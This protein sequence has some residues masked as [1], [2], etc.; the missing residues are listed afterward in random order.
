MA[1]FRINLVVN[2]ASLFWALVVLIVD[3]AVCLRRRE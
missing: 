1:W 2:Q 3:W